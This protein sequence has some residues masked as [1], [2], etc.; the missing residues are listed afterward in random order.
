MISDVPG[1]DPS[2][3]GSGMLVPDRS[4]GPA[5]VPHL[6]EP[7]DRLVKDAGP[8][9]REDTDSLGQRCIEV[10]ADLEMAKTAARRRAQRLGYAV[11]CHAEFVSGP[12]A[13]VG[14]GLAQTLLAGQTGIHLWGGETSVQLPPNPGRGGRNQ[15]LAL[16]A[17]RVLHGK[18]GVYLLSAGTDGTDGPGE[19]AGAL[20]D[21]GTID[22]G[23]AA[24]HI[25]GDPLSYL[26]RADTGTF[27]AAS[28]DLVRTGPTGTN[29]MDLMI[30]LKT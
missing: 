6:P 1:D 12:A 4:K 15:A 30:G 18:T 2:V 17:A 24:G 19:D 21:G 27:L 8:L 5:P 14:E 11:T 3:I 13:Q 23:L 7:Y 20:V 28:G 22:R 9:P 25:H 10:V 16:A 26:Q 29:V